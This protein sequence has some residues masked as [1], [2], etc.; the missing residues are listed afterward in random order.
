VVDFA[1]GRIRRAPPWMQRAGLEWLW[2]IKEQPSL[3][4]RYFSDGLALAML[5]L[6]RVLPYVWYMRAAGTRPT[7]ASRQATAS[8]YTRSCCAAPGHAPTS[9]VLR[10]AFS[11]AARSGKNVRLEMT[12]VSHV[13]SAFVGLV[14]LLLAYQQQQRRRLAIVAVPSR[15]RRVLDYCCAEFLCHV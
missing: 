2:R 7:R 11:Q 5:L 1:A 14:M 10:R 9:R 13:D 12:A 3:W 15:V 4:R 8:T 6:T